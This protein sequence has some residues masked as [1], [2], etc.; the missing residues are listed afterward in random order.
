MKKSI[1][2]M[3]EQSSVSVVAV[4]SWNNCIQH[5][6]LWKQKEKLRNVIFL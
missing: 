1:I 2:I 5:T 6:K 3:K 4:I